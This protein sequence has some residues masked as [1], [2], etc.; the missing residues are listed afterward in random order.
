M[1]YRKPGQLQPSPPF[2]KINFNIIYSLRFSQRIYQK[3]QQHFLTI[4]SFA[5]MICQPHCRTILYWRSSTAAIA[6]TWENI[7]SISNLQPLHALVAKDSPIQRRVLT[8][9]DTVKFSFFLIKQHTLRPSEGGGVTPRIL[10]HS[11]NCTSVVRL[12]SQKLCPRGDNLRYWLD[13]R[14][15]RAKSRFGLCDQD[16]NVWIFREFRHSTKGLC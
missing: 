14:L 2:L 3:S 16:R 4:W 5:M 8:L 13:R 1:L 9:Q 15:G 10:N 12:T 7:S 11:H 6:H